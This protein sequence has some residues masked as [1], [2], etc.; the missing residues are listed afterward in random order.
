MK[1]KSFCLFQE[2]PKIVPLYDEEVYFGEVEE[3]T[4]RD[5]GAERINVAKITLWSPDVIH[6]HKKGEE[7]YICLEGEG[8][9]FLNGQIFD[10]APGVRVLIKPGTLHAARPKTDIEKLIFLCISSPAF[11]PKDVYKSPLGRAW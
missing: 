11:N 7:T 10:F 2:K 5:E 9:I 1:T 6:Y 3:I 4:S 8:K